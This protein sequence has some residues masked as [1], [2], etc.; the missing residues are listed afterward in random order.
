MR[1]SLLTSM[2]KGA[3][4]PVVLSAPRPHPAALLC[5]QGSP[6]G[7][8]QLSMPR[9]WCLAPA[10]SCHA[11]KKNLQQLGVGWEGSGRPPFL[12]HFHNPVARQGA[13]R[14]AKLI[15]FLFFS[16]KF[17]SGQGNKEMALLSSA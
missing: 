11:C 8:P 4:G 7:E 6:T 9:L 5:S 3:S 16:M 1:P 10:Q 15:L 12:T 14:G 17:T 2:F 13:K